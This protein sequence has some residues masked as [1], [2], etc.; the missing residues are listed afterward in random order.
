MPAQMALGVALVNAYTCGQ[1][2]RPGFVLLHEMLSGNTE[3]MGEE[4]CFLSIDEQGELSKK[5]KQLFV[6]YASKCSLIRSWK[7]KGKLMYVHSEDIE[8]KNH[9]R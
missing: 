1:V 9:S 7:I 5:G 8:R 2:E 6:Y 4:G 3:S